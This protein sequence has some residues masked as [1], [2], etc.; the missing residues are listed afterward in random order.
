MSTTAQISLAQYEIMMET[1]VFAG[2]RR[3]RVEL[4]RGV[5]CDMNPIGN[6]HS[7]IVGQLTDWCYAHWPRA[8]FMIRVQSPLLL[9][10]VNSAP[11]PDL[12]VVTRKRY[13]RHPVPEDVHLLV[14]VADTSVNLDMGDKLSLYAKG[15]I[16]EYWVVNIPSRVIHTYQ[17]PRDGRY[18]QVTTYRDDEPIRTSANP[19]AVATANDILAILD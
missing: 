4:L 5:I 16:N 19:D 13:T 11:E 9:P 8:S 14:E 15:K 7:L 17:F 1:G 6:D 3:Q 18:R 2:V 10:S 12:A